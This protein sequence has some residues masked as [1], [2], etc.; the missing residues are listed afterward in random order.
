VKKEEEERTTRTSISFKPIL[1][2][3]LKREANFKAGG[4]V[5]TMLDKILAERYEGVKI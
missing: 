4:K 1:L 2:E 3:Q 5:S